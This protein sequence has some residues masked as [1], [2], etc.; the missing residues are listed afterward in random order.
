MSGYQARVERCLRM[1]GITT[2]T[3]DSNS[4]HLKINKI[5]SLEKR[6]GILCSTK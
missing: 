6:K 3:K 5:N 2:N 1:F 4:K